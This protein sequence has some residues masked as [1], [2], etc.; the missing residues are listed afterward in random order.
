MSATRTPA[1]ALVVRNY[2]RKNVERPKTL[3][4]PLLGG[5]HLHDLR[6]DGCCPMGLCPGTLSAAPEWR[7]HFYSLPRG[8]TNKAIRAFGNWW[9]K[10]TDAQAAVDAVWGKRVRKK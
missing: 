1:A 3:P 6:W 5:L 9:D 4:T 2:I 8:F 7:W 10:Q